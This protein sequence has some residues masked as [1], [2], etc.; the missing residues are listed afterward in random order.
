MNRL[1]LNRDI[2]KSGE[3][4]FDELM[5]RHGDLLKNHTNVQ[6]YGAEENQIY[7]D[8]ELVD[9]DSCDTILK[10]ENYNSKW[11]A[12]MDDE[13]DAWDWGSY[14]LEEAKIMANNNESDLIAI[15]DNSSSNPVCIGEFIRTE[16]G[17]E[18]KL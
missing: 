6:I 16:D 11:Y 15:I 1:Y 10:A 17:W 8:Y 2:Y 18:Y 9:R 7:S 13:N 14:D 5:N 3:W 12:V 4:L